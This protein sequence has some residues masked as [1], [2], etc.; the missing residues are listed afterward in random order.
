MLA[1]S[2][3][4]IEQLDYFYYTALTVSAL[5]EAAGT[6][7]QQAWRELLAA[8]Q[9]QLREW[10]ENYPPTFA[11]K[12]ALVSAEIAR[13]EGRDAD[14]MRL[15]EQA[16]RS[17]REHGFVQNEGVAYEVAARFYAARGVESI[18][19]AYI[20]NARD[21][22]LRWG[23]DGK[24]RQLDRL[25]PHLAGPEGRR[26]AAAIGSAVQQLDVA[27]VVKAS[28]ALSSE[29]AL[30][31]LIERLMKIAIEN[32][33]ADRGLLILPSGDEYLIQA[34]ARTTGDQIEVTMRQEPITGINC[35]E[36]LVRYVIRTHESVILDDAS[37]SQLVLC[38]RLSA[39][40]TNEVDALPSAHQATAID[41][42]SPPRKCSDDVRIHA[43]S[44]RGLGTAGGASRDLAG[45]H[46]PVQ[47]SSG[48]GGEG[49]TACRLQYHRDMHFR[50]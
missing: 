28:Q 49:P 10:A 19:D 38:G 18:A 23:A 3:G 14:A 2:A 50:F 20:R 47:R 48:T 42:D 41:R 8:H 44:D 17:A 25:Y 35:P 16:I 21:C 13:L 26:S 27:S 36:S 46:A 33:G 32:A 43:G 22:Y 31:K 45:E 29:I 7:Q 11:D 34:E 12:H 39:R 9:E 1:G 30:P 4:R 6:D 37:K 5:Y 24:V 40:P 15:Y